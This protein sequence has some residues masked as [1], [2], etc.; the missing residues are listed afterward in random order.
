VELRVVLEAN[1][2]SAG[3]WGEGEE[4]DEEGRGCSAVSRRSVSAAT[5]PPMEW[6]IRI[7]C[8]EGLTVG[9]GVERA[10]S[11]SITLF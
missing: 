5:M 10:T 6:P 8:T 9:E 7:V 4:E 3:F 1:V 2:P 11:R